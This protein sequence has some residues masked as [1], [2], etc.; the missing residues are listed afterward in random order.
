MA[1]VFVLMAIVW[2]LGVEYRLWANARELRIAIER[3]HI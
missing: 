1:W 3:R 2:A